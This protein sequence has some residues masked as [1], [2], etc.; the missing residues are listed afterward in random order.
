MGRQS[1]LVERILQCWGTYTNFLQGF[2]LY[3][4]SMAIPSRDITAHSISAKAAIE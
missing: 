3:W 1:E 2:V 4:K